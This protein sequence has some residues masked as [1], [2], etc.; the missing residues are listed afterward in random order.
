AKPVWELQLP[1]GAMAEEI[2]R[3][4]LT[5]LVR[6]HDHRVLAVDLREGSL[7]A[8]VA[9]DGRI[10]AGPVVRDGGGGALEAVLVTRAESADQDVLRAFTAADLTPAWFFQ[11]GGAFAGPPA[12]LGHEV[13][14][15]ASSGE[16]LRL[17]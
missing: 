12:A 11:D 9:V 6:T 2:V 1:G 13:F 15:P 8:E 14:L 17:R 5:V 3:A 10:L 7:D 16:V 4:D